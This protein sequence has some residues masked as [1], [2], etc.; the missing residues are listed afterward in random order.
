M[1]V[2]QWSVATD[3]GKTTQFYPHAFATGR[4]RLL[5]IENSV[6]LSGID[7]D[8]TVR[9]TAANVDRGLF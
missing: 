9:K 3:D 7:F 2:S 8:I 1:A 4:I 6:C 5:K